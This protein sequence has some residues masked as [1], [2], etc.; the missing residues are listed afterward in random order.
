MGRYILLLQGEISKKSS[1]FRAFLYAVLLTQICKNGIIHIYEIFNKLYDISV[2]T[3]GEQCM[4]ISDR[5]FEILQKKNNSINI[6]N[7][8]TIG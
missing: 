1:N 6:I 2:I 8:C 4:I 7:Q 5:I 3:E